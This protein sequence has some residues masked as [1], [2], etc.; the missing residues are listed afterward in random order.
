MSRAIRESAGETGPIDCPPP[1]QR[2]R[3]RVALRAGIVAGA[4]LLLGRLPLPQAAAAQT[5]FTHTLVASGLSEPTAMKF[6]P[7]G[8]LFVAEQGGRLRVI[9]QGVLL[10][11]PFVTLP[12]DSS[13]ER[14]LLGIA[15]HP[16][17]AS[18][19][20]VYVY[21]TARTPAVHN[22]VSRFVSA[23]DIA[24]GGEKVILEL[25]KLGATNHNGG[26][27][28]F[29]P[30][31][32]LYVAVGENVVPA[33]AQT[34]DNRLGKILRID[35]HGVIPSDNPFY[36]TASG[37]NRAIWA[38]GLRNPFTFAFQPGT[39]RMH[40]NDVGEQTWEEI[41]LGVAGANYGWPFYEGSEDDPRFRPPIYAYDHTQGC[42]IAGGVFYNPPVAQFPSQYVGDY[43]FAD[44]CG[45]WIMRRDAA[46]GQVFPFAS[47]LSRP[48]DLK[49]NRGNGSLLY[50][51][52]GSGSPGS[53]SVWKIRF[54]G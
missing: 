3:T 24:A 1:A 37:K 29:G 46:T 15:F 36:S 54:T 49:V 34:L 27:I 13:G 47:G 25:E 21:Y 45:G 5:G 4:A 39:G 35:G 14:G 20:Y 32:K 38:R 18:N 52:R 2:R 7:D 8:R 40:I 44:L 33:N 19:R 28:H 41:N 9:R 11:Q 10:P 22:R 17:F 50:L 53:G 42:A 6:A 12:V 16:D 48:V 23:G 43:F 26:A 51:Q 30:D 31:R